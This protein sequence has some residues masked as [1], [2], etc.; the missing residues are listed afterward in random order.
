M[1]GKYGGININDGIKAP[2][3][4]NPI[5]KGPA[6]NS[7]DLMCGFTID[8]TYNYSDNSIRDQTS[9]YWGHFK[10][11]Y[12]CSTSYLDGYRVDDT[13]NKRENGTNR[14]I[15]N[16]VSQDYIVKALDLTYKVVSMN[17]SSWLST[18]YGDTYGGYY[19]EITLKSHYYYQGVK[20]AFSTGTADMNGV[21]QFI[22]DYVD[23]V[24]GV[25]FH[26]T[27]TIVFTGGNTAAQLNVDNVYDPTGKGN[28]VP[29]GNGGISYSVN[30]IT[31]VITKTG[32]Y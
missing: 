12:T 16:S 28:F 1:N 14:S 21:V 31:G 25:T 20:V 9:R 19:S 17:G 7:I 5:P 18:I 29:E 15:T 3:S 2:A 24:K 30:L 6:V 26:F 10:F 11:V 8:S 32:T 13:V 22:T 23:P 27:G 4:L